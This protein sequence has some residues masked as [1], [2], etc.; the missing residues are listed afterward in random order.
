V[1]KRKGEKR[2]GRRGAE[3]EGT[4][5]FLIAR[6]GKSLYNDVGDRRGRIETQKKE[7]RGRKERGGG[8]C[9]LICASAEA[10][11]RITGGDEQN[12]TP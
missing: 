10:V 11:D 1:E 3:N 12:A 7:N 2:K 5:G 8:N 9:G 6:V 4:A